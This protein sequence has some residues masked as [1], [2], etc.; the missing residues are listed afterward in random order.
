M[1]VEPT[2][3]AIR[4]GFVDFFIARGHKFVPSSPVVPL[5]DPT[6]MFINAGMNQFKD[7]F[8]GM[9]KPDYIRTV[10]SQ[11]C[12][13]VSGKH[14]DLEEV[15]KDGYHHTFFEMLGNWSFGDYFKKEAIQWAWELFVEEWGLQADRLWAGVFAG[16]AKD[17]LSS[18]EEAA[19]IWHKQ[20]GLPLER[21]L[22][23]G[24]KDNFW[25][26]GEVG[27]C[28]PCSEIHL[29]LGE[30]CCPKKH[31]GPC[32]VNVEDEHGKCERFLELWNLVF[33]QYNRDREGNLHDLPAKH[34][35]TGL[36][37]ERMIRVLGGKKSNYETDLFTDIFAEIE[38][39]TS[40]HYN[41]Q[42]NG[43]TEI[44]FRVIADHI[45]ALTV[46]ISDG[47]LP[48]NEGRGYVL[49]RILRRAARYG[50]KL[51]VH[52][53][54]I[55]R[56]AE[57]V[58]G[59]MGTAFGELAGKTK[60][61]EE[62]LRSEEES[63][64]QTLDRGI[65]IFQEAAEKAEKR[66]Q[67]ISGE[68]A[69]KLHDT[70]GF[71]VDL[72]NLMAQEQGLK[73]DVA[74]FEKLMEEARTRARS[75]SKTTHLVA[76]E[77]NLPQTLDKP[78]YEGLRTKGKI[79]GWVDKG[80]FIEQG[81]L[82]GQNEVGLVL[83]KTCF[84][85]EQ[86]GQVGDKGTIE[87]ETGLF[88][89]SD[90]QLAAGGIIHVGRLA[91]GQLSVGQE[92]RLEVQC[93]RLDT[94]RNHTATHLLHQALREILGE[95]ARQRGSRVGPENLRFD[96]DNLKAMSKD[97]IRKVE[98]IVNEK[99]RQDVAI[100]TR[101]MPLEQAKQLPGVQA[102]FGEKYGKVVR[103]VELEDDFSRELCGGTHLER[104]GEIGLFK[105]I[106]E[107]SVAKGI[108]R[109]TAITGK[110]AFEYLLGLEDTVSQMSGL[111]KT[112][113]D[114]L[115]ERITAMQNQLKELQSRLAG[116]AGQS[117]KDYRSELLAKAER[118]GQTV[119]VIAESPPKERPEWMR[120][121]TDW[122]RKE[123]KSVAIMLATKAGGKAVLTAALSKDLV[124][125]GL[126]ASEWIG[127]AA[128]VVGGSGG[129][130][131]GLAQGGGPAAENI[132]MALEQAR[133]D[134]RARLSQE[135]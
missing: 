10:N 60:L 112:T 132:P 104:T 49:R 33:I 7:I 26:M 73:V 100:R 13:R 110:A 47:A 109:I 30:G 106:N 127:S 64:G 28:G 77:A 81:E 36:G 96:F 62:V 32:G 130:K 52:E 20:I 135:K 95:Q 50:R 92:A 121:T 41:P 126:S 88:G 82:S 125:R 80:R 56:L 44:A 116:G 133:K 120:A 8:L 38:R 12:I 23:F 90:T 17:G 69:F 11:K 115:V 122:L 61:V 128:K 124:K 123:L 119:I 87:T 63:F 3:K 42:A 51:D 134:I 98:R 103:V 107:E 114:R 27:P 94:A 2:S 105:I 25:E 16:D 59:T 111:L 29:D 102:F 54:F 117:S 99:I 86:G 85:V 6:L 22:Q 1:A 55:Y 35:D 40:R 57:T 34:V 39:L 76:V 67:P 97:E 75:A 9:R 113:P 37:L 108:R 70:Y 45:R 43:Q 24:K 83:D 118:I 15:G 18:D 79:L 65:E 5:D 131:A 91:K 84:Y 93:E 58:A 4:Q 101:E 19:Q 31:R 14:N 53:P 48:S 72:T 66:N 68:D 129:G 89:V 46:A 21:I 71:P 74:G 78:K